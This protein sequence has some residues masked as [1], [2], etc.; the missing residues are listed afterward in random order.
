MQKIFSLYSSSMS[1]GGNYDAVIDEINGL[2]Q[3]GWTVAFAPVISKAAT[4]Y[5]FSTAAII[6]LNAPEDKVPAQPR[7]FQTP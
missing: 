7:R 1:N 5:H 4:G 2:L 3:N 6:V